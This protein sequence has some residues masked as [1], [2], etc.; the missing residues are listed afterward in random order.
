MYED[1]RKQWFSTVITFPAPAGVQAT[2]KELGKQT[3]LVLDPFKA[4]NVALSEGK[5]GWGSKHQVPPTAKHGFKCLAW[6]RMTWPRE[7]QLWSICHF[8]FSQ[9]NLVEELVLKR[10]AVA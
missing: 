8:C 1:V 10:P 5:K 2:L 7:R 6:P 3:E 9:S 4:G